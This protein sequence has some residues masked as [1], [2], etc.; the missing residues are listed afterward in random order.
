[1]PLL[2]IMFYGPPGTGKTMTAQ[3]FAEYSGLEYAFMSGGDIAPLEEQAV[4][5]IHKIF[6]WVKKSKKGVLLFIDEADAF[7][8]SRTRVMS[9]HMRNSLTTI[10]YHTGTN[11]K[12]FMMILATNRPGDLDP[13]ILDRIDESV[14]FG[15][16]DN[17]E[18]ERLIQMYYE[19]FVAQPL[20]I[21][22]LEE[23][24]KPPLT[25]EP[26]VKEEDSAAGEQL[27][28]DVDVKSLKKVTSA[29]RGFSG[30]EISKLFASLQTHILY[31]VNVKHF[32][33]TQRIL[34]KVVDEKV[35]EHKRAAEF[36]SQGYKYVHN[37]V[38]RP[39]TPALMSL[40][41]GLP[42]KY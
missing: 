20:S 18:R 27:D 8:S 38:S 33:P 23:A 3:R 15:L 37:E 30:R 1:M 14:E 24:P 32:R 16:P 13:A 10:L 26:Q 11:D 17:S 19:K 40:S 12:K 41:G 36:Q 29:L 35:S 4:T 21:P 6:G 42:R 9:E 34:N 31:T 22:L 5:E 7:L 39:P 2:H 25:R 28:R